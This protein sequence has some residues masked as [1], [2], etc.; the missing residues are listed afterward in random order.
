MN[1]FKFYENYDLPTKF[2]NVSEL[3][4]FIDNLP[5][6]DLPQVFGLHSNA[7]LTCLT[8][9]A[10]YI[11]DTIVNLEPN[12]NLR[13]GTDSKES[14]VH[15]ILIDMLEKIPKPYLDHEVYFFY[16][17]YFKLKKIMFFEDKRANKENGK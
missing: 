1:K 16:L 4:D 7:D 5:N 14:V 9:R 13:S 6:V 8:K 11:I 12:E 2:K 3:Q 10:Q 17:Y 15:K